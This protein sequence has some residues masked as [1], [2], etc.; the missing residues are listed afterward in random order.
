MYFFAFQISNL[1]Q[2]RYEIALLKN[3]ASGTPVIPVFAAEMTPTGDFKP[4]DIKKFRRRTLHQVPH[5]REIS[6]SDMISRLR[7]SLSTLLSI[8]LST[9]PLC[10]KFHPAFL[11]SDELFSGPHFHQKQLHSSTASQLLLKKYPNHPFSPPT[12]SVANKF[13]SPTRY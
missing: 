8:F 10:C 5:A 13:V 12:F 1:T 6:A 3:K 7:Y 2:T 4:F 9:L 11:S